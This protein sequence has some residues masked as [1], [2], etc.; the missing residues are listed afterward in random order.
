[1][2]LAAQAW[3]PLRPDV[4]LPLIALFTPVFNFVVH[5]LWTFRRPPG[6]VD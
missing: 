4:Y 2:V 3:T 1:M 6:I 5:S